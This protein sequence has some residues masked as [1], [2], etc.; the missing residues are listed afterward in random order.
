MSLVLLTLA[1]AAALASSAGAGYWIARVRGSKKQAP[2]APAPAKTSGQAEDPRDPFEGLPMSVG[3]V[4][5]TGGEERWLSGAWVAEEGGKTIAAL[6][7][8]PE[9][10]RLCT[11]AVFVAPRREVYWLEPTRVDA[12]NEPPGTLEIGGIA[13]TRRGRWPVTLRREGTG[14]PSPGSSAIWAEYTGIS[15]EVALV[16][17][18]NGEV[19]AWKG[20]RL[21]PDQIDRLGSGGDG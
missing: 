3:D 8:A 12:P 16:V 9:G 13:H 2:A 20:R 17:A 14:A 5:A 15:G 21:E 11:V 4:V 19:S 7:F 18:G 1:A 6:F 10:A